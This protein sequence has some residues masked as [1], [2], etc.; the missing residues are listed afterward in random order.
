MN[1]HDTEF[2]GGLLASA[3]YER[4]D[5]E[6]DADITVINTCC[7]RGHAEERAIGRIAQLNRI[8]RT[9]PGYLIC[10]CGCLA[11][12]DGE[13]L[14]DKLPFVDI[15]IGTSDLPNL[16]RAISE[17]RESGKQILYINGIDASHEFNLPLMRKSLLKGMITIMRGCNNFCSY[18]IVPYVRG[19]EASR[20]ADEICDE[21]RRLIDSGAK[22]ILLLGQN[23][24]S[25]SDGDINFP[26]LLRRLDSLDK[27]IRLRFITSHPKDASDELFEAMGELSCVC[28]HLHLPMQAGSNRILGMM[29]RRYT[30]EDYYERIARLRKIIPDVAITTDLMVGYPSET[31]EEFLETLK[32]AQEIR[33]DMAFMFIYSVREKTAAAK[34]PDDVPRAEKIRRI[35]ELIRV[36]EEIAAEKNKALL[37]KRAQVLVEVQSKKSGEELLGRT[38]TDKTVIF[39]GSEALLGSFVDVEITRTSGHTLKGKLL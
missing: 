7:V 17:A 24:N 30:R 8:K 15:V 33:W 14:F 16:P 32:A 34:L 10:I 6:Q 35:Q 36:V 31:E 18:C 4:S 1:D 23:V 27:S 5:N 28:E 22:E 13:K 26:K 19:R 29:N 20:P 12:R 25:Y 37:G 2:I 39:R 38:R 21:A 3:G 11:Q 9:K